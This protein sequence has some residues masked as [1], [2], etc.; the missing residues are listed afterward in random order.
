ML[1]NL[2]LGLKWLIKSNT[3]VNRYNNNNNNNND[4]YAT[5]VLVSLVNQNKIHST[6]INL[7][8]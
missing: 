6:F 5:I 7:I 4:N 2:A 3:E 1:S 8:L